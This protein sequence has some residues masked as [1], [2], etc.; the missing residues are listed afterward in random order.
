MKARLAI[1]ALAGLLATAPALAAAEPVTSTESTYRFSGICADC[2]V[3]N[4]LASATLILTGYTP[5]TALTDDNFVSFSYSSDKETF[6]SSPFFL[7]ADD[8][9]GALGSAK[10]S[11]KFSYSQDLFGVYSL[12][13]F[14]TSSDGSWNFSSNEQDLDHGSTGVWNAASAVP[15]SATWLMMILGF[16]TIGDVMR[17]THR[18]SEE[19]FTCKIRSLATA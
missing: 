6:S 10:R 11:Y 19:K 1:V 16:G 9:S 3:P 4:S 18:K 8:I 2:N 5:G 12:N 17:R 15:E 14:Q 7:I 13:S